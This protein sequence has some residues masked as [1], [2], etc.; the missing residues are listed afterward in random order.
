MDNVSIIG[1]GVMGAELAKALLKKGY[2]VTVWNRTPAKAEPLV[3]AGAAL[4]PTSSDAI[5]A[6]PVT[7]VCIRSH[8]DTRQLLESDASAL[9]G[10]TII[11]LSTGDAPEAESL[12]NW[13]R[14]QGGECLVGMISAY[15]SGI[16]DDQTTIG[17]V[18]TES[19]WARCEPIVKTLGG[20]SIYIGDNV[21]SLAVLFSALFLPRQGFMF[22][23]LYG[24]LI[25]EKAG[26]P[27]ETYIQQIPLTIA[28]A[29]DYYKVFASTVPTNDFSNPP[30]SVNTYAAAFRDV[31]ASFRNLDINHEFPELLHDIVQRGVEAG[32][33]EEQ[34]T[35]LIKILR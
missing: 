13:V 10:A 26:V 8:G 17:I 6:S 27:V 7:I 9:S 22:G 35:A 2:R 21:S 29:N 4:A 30:A 31:L 14:E 34:L 18:G 11:E 3:A 1:L 24:A 12:V 33:G 15:P 25:C 20:K 32:Y 16:G 28:V 19:V 5:G 23:M